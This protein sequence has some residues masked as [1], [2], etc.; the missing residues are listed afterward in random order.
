MPL[1]SWYQ[2][3]NSATLWNCGT[4]IVTCHSSVPSPSVAKYEPIA[5][6]SPGLSG[7]WNTTP[8]RF[9]ARSACNTG[10]TRSFTWIDV[11]PHPKR[12]FAVQSVHHEP[13]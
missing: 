1:P 11:A 10:F 9:H 4:V 13:V 2:A 3:S 5:V 6:C 8:T 12:V 7:V